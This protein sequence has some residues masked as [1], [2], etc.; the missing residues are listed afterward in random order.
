MGSDLAIPLAWSSS[1]NLYEP[2]SFHLCWLAAGIFLCES[3]AEYR[4]LSKIEE[5]PTY[6]S[7]LQIYS[8]TGNL[9][10]LK[11]KITLLIEFSQLAFWSWRCDSMCSRVRGCF[12][13][14]SDLSPI[15]I[16]K[17]NL[18]V[19]ARKYLL[20]ISPRE[21][22]SSKVLSKVGQI[23]ECFGLK[24]ATRCQKHKE[25]THSLWLHSFVHK[26]W[27]VWLWTKAVQR[28]WHSFCGIWSESLVVH[29]VVSKG[30][31][32]RISFPI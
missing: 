30:F 27:I 4:I 15:W 14:D 22:D 28:K 29:F 24:V 25:H 7:V 9:L 23:Q 16:C 11:K 19:C 32:P 20:S 13:L 3:S 21:T 8:L 2:C 6:P 10:C 18:S 12:H 5:N 31:P 17:Q 1:C 26:I